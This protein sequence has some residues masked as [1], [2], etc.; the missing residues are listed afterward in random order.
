MSACLQAEAMRILRRPLRDLDE[1]TGQGLD[2]D[3]GLR[4]AFQ[5]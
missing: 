3:R 4:A 5:L 2:A 1:I